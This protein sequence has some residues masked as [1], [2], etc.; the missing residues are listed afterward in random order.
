MSKMAKLAVTYL[1]LS[2]RTARKDR[3]LL[4]SASALGIVATR[5]SRRTAQVKAGQVFERMFLGAADLGVQVQPM[6][7]ILQLAET[8]AQLRRLLPE[9]WGQ[10]QIAFRLGY[11]EP[12]QHTPRRPIDS[13]LHSG[14][15]L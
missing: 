5:A 9:D 1:D 8:R 6:N 7:Q 10:P 3:D 12:E 4:D 14:R 15:P 2:K 13:V 11:G